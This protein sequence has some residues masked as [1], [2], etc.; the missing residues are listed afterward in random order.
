MVQ[1]KEGLRPPHCTYSERGR[2]INDL[3]ETLVSKG[4]MADLGQAYSVFKSVKPRAHH[5]YFLATGH[6]EF[7]AIGHI[8]TPI[9]E[10]V[11]VPIDDLANRTFASAPIARMMNRFALEHLTRNFSLYL[12]ETK[13]GAIH[14]IMIRI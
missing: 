13:D 1:T 11:A 8:E 6:I 5:T 12:R 10:I 9:A 7:L 3:H 2:L 14:T 4:I